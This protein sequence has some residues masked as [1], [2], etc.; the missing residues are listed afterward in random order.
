[1][2]EHANWILNCL[3]LPSDQDNRFSDPEGKTN[4]R[5]NTGQGQTGTATVYLYSEQNVCSRPKLLIGDVCSRF[6]KRD[7][8]DLQCRY[9]KVF[10]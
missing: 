4:R 5:Q 1:M 10:H 3:H 9:A 6:N 8:Q 2:K 7:K